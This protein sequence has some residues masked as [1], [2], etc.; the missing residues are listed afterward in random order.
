MVSEIVQTFARRPVVGYRAIVLSQV[1]TGAIAFLLWVH[2]MF[3]TT[4]SMTAMTLFTA[5]SMA[6]AIPSGIQIACWIATIWT[7]RPSLRLPMLWVYGFVATFVIGGLTGVMIA[8]VPF[9]RQVHD[10][11]FIVAHF[12][13]VLIGGG[14]FPLFAALY[15]W[16][17][18]LSGRMMNE[19]L[20]RWHF[21]LFFVGV[22]LTFFPQH[23]LGLDGMPRRVYT[24]LPEMGWGR[25]N[26]LSS[27][28]A[29]VIAV[30][31]IVLLVNLFASLLRGRIAGSN[32]W[33]A[34]TLE[35]ATASPP[36][37]YGF[38]GI[39]IVESRDPLWQFVGE[40]PVVTGLRTDRRELLVTSV[41]HAKLDHREALPGP[42]VW[43]LIMALAVGAMFI[44]AVFTAWAIVW[45]TGLSLAAFAGW[46]WPRDRDRRPE[47]VQLPDGTVRE[48]LA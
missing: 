34:S 45:G 40:L 15:Y 47:W 26:L 43:P 2:H 16:L 19:A 7:G 32:P 28:G 29:A 23:L 27:L 37:S 14:V 41:R 6:I 13:Y 36:P 38:V 1:A 17:P 8:M 35:W 10:S 11:F 22:N 4:V 31:I 48:T 21:W 9:D 20:A 25:L 44:G 39:P 46:S 18:K 24:Y 42:S 5:S 12:H 30:S 3:A 33:E